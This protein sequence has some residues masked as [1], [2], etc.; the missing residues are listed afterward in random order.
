MIR[1]PRVPRPFVAGAYQAY[2]P[3]PITGR[4]ES[5]GLT[6]KPSPPK[7]TDGEGP[8]GVLG[9]SPTR[10][11][12]AQSEA[13][14]TAGGGYNLRGGRSSLCA[15]G[16]NHTQRPNAHIGY[17]SRG[18]R[19]PFTFHE[20]T[21][22]AIGQR[23]GTVNSIGGNSLSKKGGRKSM[24]I[25]NQGRDLPRGTSEHTGFKVCRRIWD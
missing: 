1:K 10:N 23:P 13:H 14:R 2:V 21:C 12:V 24:R 22:P 17:K 7:G 25:K 3:R 15:Q 4:S 5:P 20:H 18:G 16:P 9:K 19:G 6:K 11:G 8:T